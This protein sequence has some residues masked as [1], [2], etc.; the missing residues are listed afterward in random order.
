MRGFALIEILVVFGLIAI[1]GG[2]TLFVSMDTYRGS[3]FRTERDLV[4]SILEHARA[5]AVNNACLGT[6]SNG[7]PH[8]VH[9]ANNSFTL[10]QGTAYN[11]ADAANVSFTANTLFSHSG[12]LATHDV[13][14]TQLEGSTTCGTCD[15]TIS[16]STGHTSTINVTSDGKIVWTN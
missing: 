5:L 10:F 8:G 1:L 14:F 9:I 16:D 15:L 7:K 13:L 3:N 11:A 2:I 6:C 12:Y 4:V